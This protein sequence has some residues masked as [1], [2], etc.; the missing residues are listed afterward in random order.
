MGVL[1]AERHAVLPLVIEI[2]SDGCPI[3]PLLP[4]QRRSSAREPCA[5]SRWQ[6]IFL[7]TT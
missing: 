7:I 4:S 3:L 2:G 5:C 1:A 6:A